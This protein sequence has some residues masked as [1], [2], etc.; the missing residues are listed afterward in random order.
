MSDKE[1]NLIKTKAAKKDGRS[2]F[3]TDRMQS[4]SVR[5]KLVAA[6]Y[7][8]SSFV[9]C[10]PAVQRLRGIKEGLGSLTARSAAVC[11]RGSRFPCCGL[12]VSE[13]D[14]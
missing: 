13:H 11:W 5:D 1:G 9:E 7:S 10:R 4:Q 6:K 12:L 8:S 3:C 2:C 14:K